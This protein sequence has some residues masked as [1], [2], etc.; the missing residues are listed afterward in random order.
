[1]IGLHK[2]G[3]PRDIRICRGGFRSCFHGRGFFKRAAC[4]ILWLQDLSQLVLVLADGHLHEKDSLRAKVREVAGRPGVCLVFIAI[5]SRATTNTVARVA[6]ASQPPA[7]GAAESSGGGEGSGVGGGEGGGKKKGSNSLLDMQSV[8]FEGGRVVMKRYMD[9]FP[10]S[11]YL[12]VRDL[13]AL[14]HMLADLLRQ[15]FE[16]CAGQ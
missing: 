4:F 3:F 10:F 13:G 6:P 15:W 5:D 12:V 11:H 14:P 16:L 2:L 9:D 8:S 1:M 7:G